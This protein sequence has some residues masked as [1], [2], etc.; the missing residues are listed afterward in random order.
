MHFSQNP[1]PAALS[2]VRHFNSAAHA[3]MEALIDE[4]LDEITSAG[5]CP[6]SHTAHFGELSIT[7]IIVATTTATN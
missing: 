1:T 3:D 6:I 2:F 4:L 7:V 5:Y